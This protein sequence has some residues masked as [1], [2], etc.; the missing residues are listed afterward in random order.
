MLQFV[1][2]L[3]RVPP[4]D[5]TEPLGPTLTVRVYEPEEDVCVLA[6]AIWFSVTDV[7]T[8]GALGDWLVVMTTTTSTAT[9]KRA[10]RP[11][12]NVFLLDFICFGH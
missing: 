7:A 1:V 8:V 10:T 9:A 11:A 12:S 2:Q 3:F 5:V 4:P 6:A